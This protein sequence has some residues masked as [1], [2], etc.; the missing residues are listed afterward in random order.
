MCLLDEVQQ[1]QN[2]KEA[3]KKRWH[4]KTYTAALLFYET[5]TQKESHCSFTQRILL[6]DAILCETCLATVLQFNSTISVLTAPLSFSPW[7]SFFSPWESFFSPQESFFSPWESFF[8]PWESFFSPLVCLFVS[9][10]DCHRSIHL[11]IC[12]S[13]ECHQSMYVISQSICL[14]ACLVSCLSVSF[15]LFVCVYLST[16][17]SVCCSSA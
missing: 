8:S 1:S 14:S 7:E 3:L 12:H 15:C 16:C 4:C 13:S 17:L 11:F 2:P 10:F 9:M 5:T 6:H